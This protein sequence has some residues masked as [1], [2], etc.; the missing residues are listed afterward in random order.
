M[1]AEELWL[2]SARG[3]ALLLGFFSGWLLGRSPPDWRGDGEVVGGGN[4][5][6]PGYY[7]ETLTTG[8]QGCFAG[9]LGALL[10]AI[11]SF[12]LLYFSSPELGQ[13]YDSQGESAVLDELMQ[14]WLWAAMLA[15][16]GG[17]VLGRLTDRGPVGPL[18]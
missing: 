11:A 14:G 12:L 7:D 4:Y 13:V 10:A 16:G 3:A 1:P 5:G 9:S 6:L 17:W 18:E 15:W 8:G 2:L